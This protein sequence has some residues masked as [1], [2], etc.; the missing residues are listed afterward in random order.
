MS[1][2]DIPIPK[3]QY[4]PITKKIERTERKKR[5][6]TKTKHRRNLLGCYP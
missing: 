2:K 5:D 6:R 4:N 1:V 3:Y